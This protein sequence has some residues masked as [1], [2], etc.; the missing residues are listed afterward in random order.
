MGG[1]GGGW[2]G[3]EVA[4]TMYTHMNKYKKLSYTSTTSSL[5]GLLVVFH[6]NDH[7]KS[8]KTKTKQNSVIYLFLNSL[9]IYE[10]NFGHF[11]SL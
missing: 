2:Q 1:E 9:K 7:L 10:L 6:I 3:V 11:G 5:H 4:Q 8:K